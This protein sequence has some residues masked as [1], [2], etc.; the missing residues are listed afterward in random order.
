MV[1]LSSKD[2]VLGVRANNFGNLFFLQVFQFAKDNAKGLLQAP[3]SLGMNTFVTGPL[4]HEAL[5]MQK[6]KVKDYIQN[7]KLHQV[8][9]KYQ[10]NA[11]FFFSVGVPS[12]SVT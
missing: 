4:Q 7:P 2:G 11:L 6:R 5:V 8:Y 12:K 9:I 3:C 10:T 1:K